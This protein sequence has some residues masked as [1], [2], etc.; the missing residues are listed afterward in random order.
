MSGSMPTCIGNLIDL[1]SLSLTGNRLA[2]PVPSQIGLLTA[3]QEFDAS[4]C[5]F[6]GI[7]LMLL[8]RCKLI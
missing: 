2:G 1:T 8:F 3:L 5:L 4:E 7:M 6:S